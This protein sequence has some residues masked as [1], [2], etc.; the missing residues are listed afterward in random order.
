MIF[1][2]GELADLVNT[3]SKSLIK[4][5][6]FQ[7]SSLTFSVHDPQSH[8]SPSTAHLIISAVIGS[9]NGSVLLFVFI[10]IGIAMSS[11]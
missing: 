3:L 10:S 11:L 4:T 2:L 7:Q 5:N 9:Y 6:S 8:V 1:A